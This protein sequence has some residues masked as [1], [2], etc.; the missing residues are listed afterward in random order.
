MKT[1]TTSYEPTIL[2]VLFALTLTLIVAFVVSI[3]AS[4]IGPLFGLA[5]FV[6]GFCWAAPKCWTAICTRPEVK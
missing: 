5:G 2:D 1:E 4:L 6:V 3:V